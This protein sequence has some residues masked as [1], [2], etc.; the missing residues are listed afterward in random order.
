ML[1][2]QQVMDQVCGDL[3]LGV[4]HAKPH[5]WGKFLASL[6]IRDWLAA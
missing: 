6:V 3:D 5:Y 2:L 1:F 4:G